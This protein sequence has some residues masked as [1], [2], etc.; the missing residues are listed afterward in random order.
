[1]AWLESGRGWPVI[2]LHGFPLT[3]DTWRPQLDAVP[4]GWRFI[5][6]HLRGFGSGPP[7]QAP[8]SV[9]DYAADVLALLDALA[10]DDAVIGGLSMGGYVTFA[11][12][13]AAPARFTRM[14]LADTRAEADTPQG[15]EARM[16]MREL[17][18]RAGA[19]GVAAQMLPK[20]LSPAAAAE[21][22][23]FVRRTI[24]SA[25]PPAIDAALGALMDRPDSTPE[26]ARISCPVLLTVGDADAITPP[27]DAERMHAAIARASLAVIRDAGHLANLEQPAAFSRA[28]ADFL[29]SA[30]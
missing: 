8:M 20:L 6:P 28:L 9:A 30:L 3:A 10:L 23:A 13:R 25:S 7:V 26:L 21:T 4:D 12:H 24:E 29:A 5:A 11:M 22:V 1:M 14:I 2:L 16:Q 27:A 18:A 19:A 17:V 15:R